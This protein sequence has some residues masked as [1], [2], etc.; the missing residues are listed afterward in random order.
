M[1]K[2]LKKTVKLPKTTKFKF[3]PYNKPFA[4]SKPGETHEITTPL[5]NI[6]ISTYHNYSL[7]GFMEVL[8]S[9]PEGWTYFNFTADCYH[10]TSDTI[11]INFGR[12]ETVPNKNYDKEMEDYKLR[13]ERYKEELALWKVEKEKWDE[14]QTAKRQLQE[15]SEL[16]KLRKRIAELEKRFK[17]TNDSERP[18]N[19]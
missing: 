11:Y 8:R 5:K 15:K 19:S 2:K 1:P 12:Q 18:P 9:G 16:I 4:P 6:E 17:K 10:D 14:K 3:N 7:A 13:Y